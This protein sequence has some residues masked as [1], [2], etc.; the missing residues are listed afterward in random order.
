MEKRGPSCIASRNVNWYSHY[1]R[2]YG[3]SLKKLGIKL[4]YDPEIPL[5][6][7]Y[8]EETKIEKDAYT[9]VFIA[10]LF[11]IARTWK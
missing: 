2:W 1:G 3:D 10:A 8:T 9:T 11:T 7:I 4:P 5:L 6:G